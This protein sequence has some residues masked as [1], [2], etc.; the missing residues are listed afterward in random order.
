M[1][2]EAPLLRAKNLEKR[3][4]GLVAVNDVSFEVEEGGIVGLIGPNGAGKSTTFDLLTGFLSPTRGEVYLHGENI[5]TLRP[6]QRTHRGL[7]RTF[8]IAREL[9]GMKVYDN[10]LLGMQRQPDEKIIPALLKNGTVRKRAAAAEEQTEKWLKFLDL[11]ELRDEY[12]GNLSGGQRKLLELGRALMA[13]PDLLLLD[14]P[15]AGVNPELS[16]RIL[17]QIDDL[18]A[19]GVS[20]LIVEHDIDAIMGI[21]D[22]VIGMHNGSVMT[23]GSPREVQQNEEFLQAYLGG[24]V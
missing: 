9:T 2:A 18:R 23:M 19:E 16:Q 1:N 11:W 17:A 21:S 22:Q 4:S 20:F 8:Q 10:M 15:L 7:V 12:A 14:E 5:T 3:F 6:H 24:S 13:D